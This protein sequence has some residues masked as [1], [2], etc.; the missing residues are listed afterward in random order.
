MEGWMKISV[1]FAAA[2]GVV[3]LMSCVPTEPV[4]PVV[5]RKPHELE[6]HGDVRID[7]YYWLRERTNPEVLAYLEAEIPTRQQ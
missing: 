3:L 5:E 2:L 7:D 1:F 4:A 6:A